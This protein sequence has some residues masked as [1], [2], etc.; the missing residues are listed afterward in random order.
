MERIDVFSFTKSVQQRFEEAR[1]ILSFGEYLEEVAKDPARHCRNSTQYIQDAFRFYGTRTVETPQGKEQRFRIFDQGIGEEGP[2]APKASWVAGQEQ[3]QQTLH[4][5]LGNFVRQGRN[6]RLLLLHGPNGS[7]KSSIVQSILDALERYAYTPEGV[8]YRFNWIFPSERKV[9]RGGIGFSNEEHSPIDLSSYAHLESDQID[10]RL[11][12][13]M[14]DHPLLLLP[15]PERHQFLDQLKQEGKFPKEFQLS[16]YLREGDL[17]ARNRMIFDVLLAHYGGDFEEVLRHIQVERFYASQRYRH[18]VVQVEPQMHVDAGIRQV[19][20]DHSLGALPKALSTLN[21]F[22]PLGALV[23]ANRGVIEYTDLLKRPVEAFKYLLG[24][25]ETGRATV[26]RVILFLDLLMVGTANEQ[27]LDRFKEIAEFTSFKSRIELIRVPYL[28]RYSE[29]QAIYDQQLT[30]SNLPKPITPHVTEL[31]A[32]WAVMTRLR[33]PNPKRLPEEVGDLAASLA[34]IEKTL[35]Y[36][37]GEIPRR[38]NSKQAKLLRQHVKVLLE[39]TRN[40]LH[41]EG[42]I[43]ASPREIRILLLNAA[44][45]DA[46]PSVSPLALFEEMENLIQERSVYEFLQLEA[47]E[48]YY[49]PEAFIQVLRSVHLDIIDSEFRRASGLVQADQF[50][51]QLERYI[52]HVKAYL[53]KEKINNSVTQKPEDPDQKFMQE[54][55]VILMSKDEAHDDFRNSLIS[56]VA[57][58]SL[59]NPGQKID[60]AQLFSD[61]VRTLERDF[62]AKHKKRLER[63]A[64]HVLILLVDTKHGLADSEAK[65]AQETIQKLTED[66][67]YSK[68]CVREMVGLLVRKRYAESN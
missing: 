20:A 15:R 22:E 44:Q 59:E 34:P 28:L 56:K 6:T 3:A 32:M 26:D 21:L 23:D 37:H 46:Y 58:S 52:E 60:L 19:T 13:P 16:E 57:A 7:G 42:R 33:R 66:F 9:K 54:V 67:G 40:D 35:L 51:R 24:T 36:D 18:A 12:S 25:C 38:F 43:G 39:E 8:L 68:P 30:E 29:E 55:E 53:R 65:E 49:D 5:M 17:S 1:S 27:N 62:F 14:K 10:A 61:F 31:A 48:G 41:Y 45:N 11:S 63:I 4:R 2:L 47:K 50:K 64:R